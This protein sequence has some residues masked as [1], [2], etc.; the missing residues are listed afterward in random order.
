MELL[1]KLVPVKL[2]YQARHDNSDLCLSL[3]HF[4]KK[5][6]IYNNLN[7]FQLLLQQ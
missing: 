1:S 7:L 3:K 5:G 6:K 2:L 4:V